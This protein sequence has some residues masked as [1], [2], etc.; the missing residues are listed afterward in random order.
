MPMELCGYGSGG[1]G[2]MN[3]NAQAQDRLQFYCILSRDMYNIYKGI[4]SDIQF[5]LK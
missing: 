1:S 4:F 2:V 3:T 5:V